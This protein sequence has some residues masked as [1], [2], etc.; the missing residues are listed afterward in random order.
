MDGT[1]DNYLAGSLGIGT[2]SLTGYTVNVGK[3]ITGATTAYG[4]RS[5]GTVQSDV[6]TLVSNYGSLMNTAAASFT[7]TDFVHHRSMQGTIGSGSAVTNQYGY[8]ADSSMTGATNNF[9]FYGNIPSGS[10]RWNIYMNGTANNY[11]AGALGIGTT[12]LG[13]ATIRIGK[14]GTG[15]INAFG[16][17][18]QT[19][20]QSDVTNGGTGYN[21]YLGTQAASF[22]LVN[23]KHYNASVNSIG[24][25]STIT[26]QYGFNVDS[27]CVGATNNFGFVGSIPSAANNWNL[28]MDGTAN[29][30]LACSLGIG[31]TSSLLSVNNLWV[32]KSMTGGTTVNNITSNGTIQSDVTSAARYY[33][34]IVTTA[35][36]TFTVSNIYH[37]FADQGTFGAGSTVTNQYGFSVNSSLIGATNNYAFSSILSS[38]SG[39]WNLYMSGTA[40]NYLAGA[41]SIGVTTANASALLQVDSTTQGVLFPRMTTTQKNAISSPAVGLIIYDT[42]LNKL[43]VYTGS[44]QTITSA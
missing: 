22:T 33:T 34:S 21:S 10:N 14:L 30:Y 7:L 26:R 11:L 38:G 24:A 44:W 36:T 23:F 35:A 28:Y 5:Q 2:T 17:D 43:C 19:I 37:F 41:L 13:N 9:G 15:A 32:A 42:T 40:Q 39:R 3:N 20:F 12:S 18:N 1:A 4:V 31:T 29:N 6:T 16:I 27:S 25:G 8:F